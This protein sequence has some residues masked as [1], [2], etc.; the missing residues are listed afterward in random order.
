[1]YKYFKG[2]EVVSETKM[3]S[4]SEIALDYS[5]WQYHEDNDSYTYI[6]NGKLVELIIDSF[7]NKNNFKV[8]SYYYIDDCIAYKVFKEELVKLAMDML[9]EYFK[10]NN[11]ISDPDKVYNIGGIDFIYYEH[12]KKESKII[13]YQQ[14]RH[15]KEKST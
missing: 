11:I 3:L 1:M 6:P 13:D 5:L 14:F 9:M 10:A 2:T 8:S 7:I 12:V 4:G 15:K